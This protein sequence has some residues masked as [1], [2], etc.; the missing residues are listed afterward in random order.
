MEREYLPLENYGVIGN[1]NTVALIS[2]HG[3]IDYLCLPRFD[4]PTT[5]GALLDK[6]K[7]GYFCIQPELDDLSFKQLYLTDTAILVTRFF[8]DE[9]IAELTD[10][11]AV[12]P[13]SDTLTDQ[14][15][16]G[17]Q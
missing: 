4:S 1:L 10:F 7:G 16:L 2:N 13:H 3:S 17:P 8:A 14:C 11:M 12:N 9:G 6:E 15:G 5:F